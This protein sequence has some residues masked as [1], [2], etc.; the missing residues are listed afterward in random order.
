MTRTNEAVSRI[1]IDA[2]LKDEGWYVL[3]TNILAFKMAEVAAQTLF[4]RPFSGEPAVALP[5]QEAT[6][7]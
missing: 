3:A 7:A 5:A 6:I 2:L 1:K 4:A